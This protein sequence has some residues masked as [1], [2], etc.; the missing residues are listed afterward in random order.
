MAGINTF[1]R[2]LVLIIAAVMLALSIPAFP[3]RPRT[4]KPNRA[5]IRS[6][7]LPQW[8]DDAKFGIFIHWTLSSVPGYAP[9]GQGSIVDIQSKQGVKAQLK[10]NPYAEWYL[11]TMKI[12]GSPTQKYHRENYGPNFSYDDFVPIFNHEIRQW[13]PEQWAQLF[14][15]VGARYV[16]LVTKHHD[17]FLLWPSA[18]PNP[19]KQNYS[20][21]RDIVGE[22]TNAVRRH[23]MKMG[24]YYSGGLDWT[25]NP[26][27]IQD[28]ASFLTSAPTSQEYAEY[29]TF[30]WKELI[31]R[32]QPSILWNDICYPRRAN[33]WDLFAY[34]YNHVPDGVVNDRWLKYP[35]LNAKL[36]NSWP[37]RNLINYIGDRMTGSSGINSPKPPFAD[38][39]TPEY[40]TFSE[41]RNEKWEA[42]RGIGQSF[43]Y[44]R[45]ETAADYMKA[46]EAVLMLID[47]V[48]KNGNLLLDIGPRADGSIPQEQLDC[49]LG[50]GAW[51]KVNGDA[52]YGT[53]P[54]V[55]AEGRTVTGTEIRFTQK[56][57]ELFAILMDRPGQNESE[58]IGLRAQPGTVI[59]MLGH[60]GE[61]A[62]SQQGDNLKVVMPG[63]IDAS[64]AF[65]LRFSR[66][67]ESTIK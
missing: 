5:S 53:R 60:E 29:V 13:E 67:P 50:I 61:L 27:P 63:K 40:V 15:K 58:I 4:Y 17:G 44:N 47:I 10:N 28:A 14:E 25:F 16:V 52:I 31:N 34:Y 11:N 45:M 43:G 62:W 66:L 48:S 38:F 57:G 22:L 51:L 6:H 26:A 55:R 41:T 12:D 49:L 54:W 21:S 24:L 39:V 32:Y 46:S 56:A 35:P 37:V 7:Q 18:R 2:K 1:N 20:A 19:F 23:G 65:V 30:H 59:S 8:Y 36:V 9:V 42:V 3:D 33:L 64:P